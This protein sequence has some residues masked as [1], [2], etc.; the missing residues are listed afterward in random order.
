MKSKL[1]RQTI[2]YFFSFLFMTSISISPVLTQ[3]RFRRSPPNPDPLQRLE[4]P[5]IESYTLSNGLTLSVVRKENLPVISLRLIIKTGESQSPEELPGFATFTAKMVSTGAENISSSEMEEEIESIGGKFSSDIYPDYSIFSFS[6]LE[7]YFEKAIEILSKMILQPAF[8]QN[9]IEAVKRSIYYD[10]VKKNND[11]KFLT[12]KVLHQILFKNHA[13][14]KIAYNEDLIKNFN[15]K[16]LITFFDKFYRPNN[17]ILVLVGNLNLTT[18]S[19]IVSRHLNLWEKKEIEYLYLEIPEPIKAPKICFVEL[20]NSK[21]S[22]IYIGSVIPPIDIEEYFPFLVLNQVL[23]GTHNS[24]LF[25]NLRESKSYAYYAFSQIELFKT[26][27]VFSIMTKVKPEVTYNSI[28]ECMNEIRNVTQ[29]RL[30]N[31]EIE[32]AKSYI[33]RNFPL[34]IE[35]IEGLSSKIS[36]NQAFNLNEKHWNKYYESIMVIDPGKVF[37]TAQKYS[38]LAPVIVIVGDQKIL[39][40]HLASFQEV[41]VYNSKGVFQYKQIK[42][43]EE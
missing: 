35:D 29:N 11:P 10:L 31:F 26:C 27:S 37:S 9:E 28:I 32:K 13:Y 6:F 23:G 30:S 40:N 5:S 1:N 3:E 43:V 36:E 12:K 17:S 39:A 7:E 19:R 4:L 2:I 38:L 16:D 33:I 22:T 14:K 41:E 8:A 25:M 21:D 15:R 34:S 42:G 24:R 20:P 18:A